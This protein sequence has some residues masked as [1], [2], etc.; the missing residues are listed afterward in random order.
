MKYLAVFVPFGFSLL[1]AL[2]WMAAMRCEAAEAKRT[3]P[4]PPQ[5]YRRFA[6]L[7]EGDIERGKSLFSDAT[8]VGCSSC[9]SVDG[10]ASKAGPDLFAAGDTFTRSDLI[11]A[12]LSPSKT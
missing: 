5:E 9:H 11:D 8:K 3:R 1:G 7:H 12:I 6:M 10:S 2:C 4:R